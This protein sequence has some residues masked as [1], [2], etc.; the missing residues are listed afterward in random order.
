M[1]KRNYVEHGRLGSEPR[2]TGFDPDP[3]SPDVHLHWRTGIFSDLQAGYLETMGYER[4]RTSSAI[5]GTAIAADLDQQVDALYPVT[6]YY[7]L[8]RTCRTCDRWFIFFA[9]EQKHWYEVL[10]FPLE[11]DCVNCYPCRKEMQ[12][13]QKRRFRYEELVKKEERTPDEDCELAECRLELMSSGVFGAKQTQFVREF[14]NRHP[15]HPRADEVR[16]RLD[17]LTIPSP[18]GGRQVR[19]R[20]R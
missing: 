11:S 16:D 14:L 17:Q 9:E 3:D 6:H 13:L 18:S 7:D 15:D 2:I 12:A 1:P 4:R 19:G 10:L 5:P 20:R 8:E